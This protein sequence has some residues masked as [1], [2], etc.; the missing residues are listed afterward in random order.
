MGHDFHLAIRQSTA[1]LS[2]I[3]VLSSIF[4]LFG[5]LLTA[6]YAQMVCSGAGSSVTEA[7]GHKAAA[8]TVATV[9]DAAAPT[10]VTPN[11]LTVEATGASS[12]S[13][14]DPTAS[15]TADHE[16]KI[17]RAKD[18]LSRC[19]ALGGPLDRPRRSASAGLPFGGDVGGENASTVSFFTSLIQVAQAA[20]ADK[21]R[22]LAGGAKVINQLG[23]NTDTLTE[24]KTLN[25]DIWLQGK[26]VRFDNDAPRSGGRDHF[27]IFYF[28]IDNVASPNLR[29]GALIQYDQ[30]QDQSLELAT[31]VSGRGW[32]ESPY[33]RVKLSEALFFQ[34]RAAWGKS[35]NNVSPFLTY[36]DK[37]EMTRWLV[38]GTPQGPWRSGSWLRSPILKKNKKLMLI[39]WV[40]LIQVGQF[41]A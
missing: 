13:E 35:R 24:P 27:S 34:A 19:N 22:K 21:R 28:G 38:E 2:V 39:P 14:A 5:P 25:L 23:I 40:S 7:G 41:S 29:I 11:E 36:T 12:S 37:F 8:Q 6:A 1:R 16:L 26:H 3:V 15:F 33:A 18:V 4:S 31:D 9:V 10:I 20:A 32:M 30:M 17:V